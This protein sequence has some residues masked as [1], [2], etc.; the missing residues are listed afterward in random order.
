MDFKRNARYFSKTYAKNITILAI[1][2]AVLAVGG[3]LFW[4]YIYL[5]S[6]DIIV[7]IIA[8]GGAIT[9]VAAFSQRP[10]EKYLFEQIETAEKRFRD[11]AMDAYGYPADAE[12]CTRLVW[13]FVPG[14]V[15]KT[16]KGGKKATDRL[17]FALIWLKKGE[18]AVR[19]Q[20]CGLLTEEAMVADVRL[21][22]K[23]LTATLDREAGELTLSTADETMVLSVFEPD[24]KLE[25]FLYEITHRK[26]K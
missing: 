8:I 20:N 4:W 9:A 5:G 23:N 17:E 14:S 7:E 26:G 19:R 13:G 10:S 3:G 12:N 1:V 25:E 16:T 24:Y 21:S 15:E 18:L 22:L 11:E 6:F 2:S